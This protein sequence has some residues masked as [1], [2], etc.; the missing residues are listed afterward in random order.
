[1]NVVNKTVLN[2]SSVA[3][4]VLPNTYTNVSSTNH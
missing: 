2:S 3:K 1:M 4:V